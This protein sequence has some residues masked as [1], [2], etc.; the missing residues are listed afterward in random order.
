[1]RKAENIPLFYLLRP[2]CLEENSSKPHLT[3]A[4]DITITKSVCVNPPALLWCKGTTGA[5][6][7]SP[8]QGPCTPIIIVPHVYLCKPEELALQ[9]EGSQ[10]KREIF[11]PLLIGLGL[12]ISLGA[13]GTAGE[14]ALAQAQHLA[15]RLTRLPLQTVLHLFNAR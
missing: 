10:K 3:C 12:A 2:P 8:L 4:Y 14:A 13:A 7:D 5:C 9:M 1:M 11:I 15:C 6:I